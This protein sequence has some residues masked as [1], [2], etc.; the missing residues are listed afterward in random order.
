MNKIME[1]LDGKKS[2]ITF[3]IAFIIGGL[4]AVGIVD[5]EFAAKIDMILIPLGLGFVRAGIAKK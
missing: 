5:A 2:Y 3:A 1:L 4:S